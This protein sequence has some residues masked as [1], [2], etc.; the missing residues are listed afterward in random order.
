MQ[1]KKLDMTAMWRLSVEPIQYCPSTW[2]P[3]PLHYADAKNPG[4]REPLSIH[5][6]H[7]QLRLLE[8]MYLA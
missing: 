5:I 7:P 2:A 8:V 4:S 1:V 3:M 6:L